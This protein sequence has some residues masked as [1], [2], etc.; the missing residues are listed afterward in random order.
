MDRV[1]KDW[2]NIFEESRQPIHDVLKESQAQIIEI[3]ESVFGMSK[4]EIIF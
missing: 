3:I 1:V 2:V 4:S